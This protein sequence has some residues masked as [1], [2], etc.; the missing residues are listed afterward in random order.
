[1]TPPGPADEVGPP[2]EP[3]DDGALAEAITRYQ[4]RLLAR[5]RLMMGPAARQCL[6]SGDVLHDVFAEALR[7][8]RAGDLRD[9]RVFLRWVTAVARN[10]IIDA[11]RRNRERSFEALTTDVGAGGDSS[12]AA[13]LTADERRARLAEA[14]RQLD[15]ARAR[16]LELRALELGLAAHRG[17]GAQRGGVRSSTTALPSS[18]RSSGSRRADDRRRVERPATPSASSTCSWRGSRRARGT[19]R[20]PSRSCARDIRRTLPA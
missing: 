3:L 9:E 19:A 5:I 2:R 16:V 18:A 15:P 1:M 11:V 6:E 4:A 8:L 7:T 13:R 12:V 17:A 14:I 20:P 10:H